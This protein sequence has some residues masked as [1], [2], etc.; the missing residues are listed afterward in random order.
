MVLS[1][2]LSA[3]LQQAG[4]PLITFLNI[5][6]LL[7]LPL[8]AA[9][10]AVHLLNRRRREVIDWGA[11]QFLLEALPRKRRLWQL[12]DRLLMLLR[13]L[14]VLLFVL[15]IARPLLRSRL[16]GTSGQRDVVLVIDTSMSTAR[17]AGK[18]S[19]LDEIIQQAQ[20]AITDLNESD[21]VR[22]LL[23]DQTPRWL[24]K[25]FQRIGAQTRSELRARIGQLRPTLGSVDWPR[26][27]DEA[28]AA[29]DDPQSVHGI[30]LFTD[31]QARGWRAQAG[32]V[33][34]GLR[35]VLD[36]DR[37]GATANVVFHASMPA[38]ANLAVTSV[39]ALRTRVGVAET[40]CLSAA[41]RNTGTA[42][43]EPSMLTWL[44][45]ETA[46]GMSPINPLAAGESTTVPFEH[47]FDAPGLLELRARVDRRDLLAP[48]NE[49]S[50]VVEV[51]ESIPVLIVDGSGAEDTIENQ[52]QYL[53]AALGRQPQPSTDRPRWSSVF[54]PQVVSP[55]SLGG[56]DLTAYPA[57]VLANVSH[58][59]PKVV[60]RLR[61]FVE[62]GGGVWLLPG[63][64]LD[65]AGFTA[66]FCTGRDALIPASLE[67][68]IGDAD[69]P[70]RFERIIPPVQPQ[71]STVLLADTQRLDLDRVQVKRHY[72]VADTPAREISTLLALSNNTPVAVHRLL[73]RG[74]V[75]LQTLPMGTSWSNLPLLQVYVV[76][77]NEWLAWLASPTATQWNL[78]PGQALCIPVASTFAQEAELSTPDGRTVRVDSTL[79]QDHRV[80]RSSAA[81]APGRYTL[82]VENNQHSPHEYPIVV[83]RDPEESDLTMLTAADTQMLSTAAGLRFVSRALDGIQTRGP[84][85]PRSQPVWSLLLA[86]LLVLLVAE[87]LLA[88]R[89]SRRRLVSAESL[90]REMI[91]VPARRP[92]RSA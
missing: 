61:A 3:R 31:G 69:D 80:F 62:A 51:V 81:S 23:A 86:A 50:L 27:V 2:S 6:F 88:G 43:S 40:L 26:C 68:A 47:P 91:V 54:Q 60:A 10:V 28:A 76:W 48:D 44:A 64:G 32:P 67:E 4:S 22:V 15:A 14:A 24:T 70:E 21:R 49:W 84:V 45:G 46:L 20:R 16:L 12:D 89:L 1:T 34:R 13:C 37:G 17:Q 18:G 36:P 75:I 33:W 73:G 38:G 8:V 92:A 82:K 58:L 71:P 52:T 63:D 65:R 9:P 53:L 79:H 77:V 74:H 78:T 41:I 29:W 39:T 72:R 25:D 83:Q 30:V 55:G 87:W 35:E 42:A 90:E 85:A 19:T 59:D 56:Y 57:I 11:M 66:T 7:G 5:A